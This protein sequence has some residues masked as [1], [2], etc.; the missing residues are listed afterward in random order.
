[1]PGIEDWKTRPYMTIRQIFEEHKGDSHETF[2]KSVENY[3][4][5]RCTEETLKTLPSVNSTPLDQLQS[6]C[7]VK[8]RCM[9]QDVFDPQ[10]FVGRYSVTNKDSG[11]T[12][13]ECGSF[14]DVPLIGPNETADFDSLQNVTV[15]RHGFYCVPIPGEASWCRRIVPSTSNSAGRE[16]RGRD[17]EEEDMESE[18]KVTK[19]EI[20]ATSAAGDSQDKSTNFV[21]EQMTGVESSGPSNKTTPKLPS[22][23]MPLPDEKGVPCIVRVYSGDIEL[24][25]TSVVEIVG[26]LCMDPRLASVFDNEDE[27]N[28]ITEKE[29]LQ[30][31]E[32]P[33]SLVPRLHALVIRHMEHNNPSLSPQV[34]S[35]SYKKAFSDLMADVSS[36]RL[37]LLSILEHALLGD[38]LAA[39]YLL[40]QLISGVY[41]R[42]DVLPLGKL[43]VNFSKC[44]VWPRYCKFLHHLLSQLTTQ[45]VYLDITLENMNSFTLVPKKDYNQNRVTAGMLQLGSGTVLVLNETAL[46]QGQLNPQGVSNVKALADVIKWQRVDY[47][48]QW[49]PIPVY[50]NVNVLVF[51]E[52]E[53]LLPKDVHLPL[54]TTCHDLDLASHFSKLDSRLTQENLDKLRS[55]ISACRL[56]N[57]S[58][59]D[60]TQK[61]IQDDFVETRQNDPNKMSVED[62][63]TLLVVV[64]LICLSHGQPSP[65]VAMWCTAKAMEETRKAR[66]AEL[67]ASNR[68]SS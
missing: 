57:Y 58:V 41:A 52:G 49:H 44:P 15:E 28:D 48:F 65:N 10:Y 5:Q 59:S 42:V 64:R 29:E 38:R 19:E 61:V 13:I 8:Y 9:V 68:S 31:H 50:T 12:R 21:D 23:N 63:Q 46:Q 51:S 62:F 20:T 55:Y 3:F 7:V 4:S 67:P 17:P 66:V 40:C 6:G 36:L 24:K 18:Q 45:S 60:E 25:T 16:K 1:M 43:C 39:E 2:I 47:D 30:A 14:R 33:A 22:L 26:I 35:E 53:S 34:D 11:H 32:P 27:S 56:I 54:L 37:E